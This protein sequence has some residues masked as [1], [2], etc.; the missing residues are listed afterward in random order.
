M[1]KLGQEVYASTANGLSIIN[2][3]T[4]AIKDLP[5]P[6]VEKPIL[7]NVF[8]EDQDDREQAGPVSKKISDLEYPHKCLFSLWQYE[9]NYFLGK[10][11][12]SY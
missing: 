9:Y 12:I 10:Q 4:K 1:I 2:G 5:E 11:A 8:Q 3:Q 6:T 7:N